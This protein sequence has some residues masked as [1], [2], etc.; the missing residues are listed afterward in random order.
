MQSAMVIMMKCDNLTLY[1]AE[2]AISDTLS[3][4]TLHWLV[5]VGAGAATDSRTLTCTDGRTESRPAA[6]EAG[7]VN[8]KQLV[9]S[10]PA[11][12]L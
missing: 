11:S 7:S 4:G 5:C 1:G 8:W 2:T 10:R 12:A 3:T 6:V 9:G